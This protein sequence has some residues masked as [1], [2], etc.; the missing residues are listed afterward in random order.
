MK[1]I[2]HTGQCASTL[3]TTLIGTVNHHTY[4]EPPWTHELIKQNLIPDSYAPFEGEEHK[5]HIVKFPSG[6]CATAPLSSREKV[7]IYRKYQDH[8]YRHVQKSEEWPDIQYFYEYET[9]HLHPLLSN[10]KVNKGF[11]KL[12]LYWAN[13]VLWVQESSDVMWIDTNDFCKD[14]EL[15]TNKSCEFLEIPPVTDFSMAYWDVKT[16]GLKGSDQPLKLIDID[17][18]RMVRRNPHN[19][20]VHPVFRDSH[21]KVAEMLDWFKSEINAETLQ[22]LQSH[23]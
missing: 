23:L 3:L 16:A 18:S 2:F 12:S 10:V 21:K 5:E 9:S 13:N 11:E 19:G 22:R 4:S 8:I 17:P 20:A 7:F 15:L 1:C 14:F 6:L